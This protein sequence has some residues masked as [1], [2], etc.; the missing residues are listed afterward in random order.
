MRRIALAAAVLVGW[1]TA[2]WAADPATQPWPDSM[3]KTAVTAAPKVDLV[4]SEPIP[5]PKA[6]AALPAKSEPIPAPKAEAPAASVVPD[7]GG[8]CGGCAAQ[9]GGRTCCE[10]IRDWLC[11]RPLHR[12]CCGECKSCCTGPYCCPPPLYRYFLCNSCRDGC[13]VTAPCATSCNTSCGCGLG[14]SGLGMFRSAT[15]AGCG[16]GL[17]GCH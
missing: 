9:C 8:S 6:D 16:C 10:R 13:A 7:A 11:Y 2:S 17:S 3:K 4:K 1:A 14:C 12:T 15:G 5:P